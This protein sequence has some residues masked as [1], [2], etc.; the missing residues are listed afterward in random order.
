MTVRSGPGSPPDL[1]PGTEPSGRVT[2]WLLR[3]D[4]S[5]SLVPGSVV[6]RRPPRN[7]DDVSDQAAAVCG[8]QGHQLPADVLMQMEAKEAQLDNGV[9]IDEAG[10]VG[11]SSN[12]NVAFVTADGVFRH[13]SS[14]TF[15]R[16]ARRC[17][18]WSLRRARYAEAC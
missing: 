1:E 6:H 14:T 2:A 8:D 16:V 11:E 15:W 17:G 7:D 12:M 9:F 4:L 5:R 18:C 3:D 10:H 13:R